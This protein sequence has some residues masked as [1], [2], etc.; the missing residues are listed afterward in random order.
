MKLKLCFL[1]FLCPIFR[2]LAQEQNHKLPVAAPQYTGLS[3]GQVVPDVLISQVLNNNGGA[4]R[5]SD[6]R[7]RLLIL[8]FWATSCAGCIQA[9]PRLDSLQKVSGGRVVI[10]P[11]TAEKRKRVMAFQKANAFLQGWKFRTVVEDRDLHALFPHRL[12][13]H[14]VWID[15]TG[16]VMA[17]TDVAAVNVLA[18]DRALSG[19]QPN[20]SLKADVLSYQR[21][22]PLLVDGNGAPDSAYRYRSI[23]TAAIPGLPS[24][25][26][27]HYDSLKAVIIVRAS[28]VSVKLLYSLAFK[29]L[30]ELPKDSL[31]LGPDRG[32]YCYE[33]T[34]PGRSAIRARESVRQDLD[35]FFNVRSEWIGNVFRLV[36]LPDYSIPDEPLVL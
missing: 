30:R 14:E 19:K 32:L 1:L 21:N 33:L 10:L 2:V 34:L 24:F 13:P 12:V 31:D 23:I 3:I 20:A 18:I 16:H 28:N 15:S 27:I 5:L 8:D 36:P 11:V 26:S 35:R 6:F 29:K 4:T 25:I 22:K 17:I 9:M 7:G